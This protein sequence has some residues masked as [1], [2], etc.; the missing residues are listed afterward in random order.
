MHGGGR[1][2]DLDL[3]HS[4]CL[5]AGPILYKELSQELLTWARA[6]CQQHESHAE[7]PPRL[8]EGKGQF[9]VYEQFPIASLR[10]HYDRSIL[11]RE[12]LAELETLRETYPSIQGSSALRARARH[13][14]VEGDA[15]RFKKILQAYGHGEIM[16]WHPDRHR[17]LFWYEVLGN[18]LLGSE[19]IE[20]DSARLEVGALIMKRQALV[21]L[22]RTPPFLDSNKR[23][24]YCARRGELAALRLLAEQEP[25]NMIIQACLCMLQGQWKEAHQHFGAVFTHSDLGAQLIQH[26]QIEVALPLGILNAIARQARVSVIQKW[27]HFAQICLI[28]P[29]QAWLSPS[30]QLEQQSSLSLLE[31]LDSIINRD[32]ISGKEK[33]AELTAPLRQKLA[34][35]SALHLLLLTILSEHL[36]EPFALESWM[37]RKQHH[38]DE[39]YLHY[40]G[41]YLL[42][43]DSPYSEQQLTSYRALIHPDIAPLP[44]KPRQPS[45]P[46]PRAASHTKQLFWD[47]HLDAD[48]ESITRIEARLLDGNSEIQRRGRV[49]SLEKLRNGD[50]PELI[51][52]ADHA[53]LP[54]IKRHYDSS[55]VTWQLSYRGY[56]SLAGHPRLRL[57]REGGAMSPLRLHAQQA[58]LH[59]KIESDELVVH[60]PTEQD[61]RRLHRLA[62]GSYQIL[63]ATPRLEQ[64]QQLLGAVPEQGDY[65]LQRTKHPELFDLIAQ[66]TSKQKLSPPSPADNPAPSPQ[67]ETILPLLHLSYRAQRLEL[68]LGLRI[69]PDSPIYFETSD[70][71]CELLLPPPERRTL[72]IHRNKSEEEAC[73]LHLVEHCPS[74]LDPSHLL[75]KSPYRWSIQGLTA[76]LQCLSELEDYQ[77]SHSRKLELLWRGSEPLHLINPQ[78]HSLTLQ[79]RNTIHN[80]F[81][82]GAQLVIDEQRVYELRELAQLREQLRGRFL[83]LGQGEYLALHDT[84]RHQ[85]QHLHTT[86]HQKAGKLLLPRAAL[87]A[88]GEQWDYSDLDDNLR[89]QL[90]ALHHQ[91]ANDWSAPPELHAQL[92]PYQEL[93]IRWLITRAQQSL[94]CCLADDMGLGKTLQI[95][96]LLLDQSSQGAS[97]IIAPVSLLRNWADEAARF[98]PSLRIHIHEGKELHADSLHEG[99]LYLASYGQLLSCPALMEHE[100]NGLIL[101]EAQ[102]IKNSRS[103]RSRAARQ[104]RARFRVAATGTPVENHLSDIW[105][106]MHFLNPGLLGQHSHFLRHMQS[107]DTAHQLQSLLAPLILR[108]HKNDVLRELPPLTEITLPV[109]LSAS[110]RALYEARRRKALQ[111]LSQPS[112]SSSMHILRELTALRRLCCHSGLV[113]ADATESSK[114]DALQP[115]LAGLLE[116]QHRVLIFSQFTD[117]LQLARTRLDRE[118]QQHSLYLDGNTPAE[119]R[120]TLIARFQSPDQHEHQLFY[121]SLKAGGS[122]LNLTAADYVILLDPWWNPAIEAQ[123]AA[124]AHRMGQNQPVT[125]YRLICKDSVE[126]QILSL[127]Q[128]KQELSE[129]IDTLSRQAL[130][131][132]LEQSG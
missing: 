77:Q 58:G 32:A 41:C 23:A 83:P 109:E 6:A 72:S 37:L 73:L 46:A 95:L 103:Q 89:S 26:Q 22:S 52:K 80:W 99:S 34:H 128:Q 57:I 130:M 119:E 87:L 123:A 48:Q 74:L 49:L 5:I 9:F 65:K 127:H 97:L 90:D 124:R 82:I 111:H 94:G 76:S 108:R 79:L 75:D 113:E 51:D 44:I 59:V 125:L 4:L 1:Q 116:A 35:P 12:K 69:H 62:D 50:Y 112:T 78:S 93:G 98:T 16:G 43:C 64:L 96:A 63:R 70:Q 60:M 13:A 104:L 7:L 84:Q 29:Q 81:E 118:L 120:A 24:V 117:V 122:G 20:D 126:E 38:G 88:L 27:L 121:I 45:L 33:L 129:H 92:R 39:L 91:F 42:S 56:A 68:T 3:I 102:N 107:P 19:L 28:P 2:A 30:E 71:T 47:I 85:L 67:P 25:Q 17:E 31:L 66:L 36:Q 110:E 131:Q 15:A 105:S 101:D 54:Q 115:L 106:L 14:L 10:E 53:I 114:L 86:L 11:L 21:E 61:Y 18:D 8:K 100:W 40:L 55:R 132:L